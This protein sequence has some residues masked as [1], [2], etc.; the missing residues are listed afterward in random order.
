MAEKFNPNLKFL[1]TAKA[2]FVC[3][4]G[5][6]FQILLIHDFIGCPQ[7]ELFTHLLKF[8]LCTVTFGLMYG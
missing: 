3:H 8:I 6:F 4:I 5:P 1:G 2:Y 7:S